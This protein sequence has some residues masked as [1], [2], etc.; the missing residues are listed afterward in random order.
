[1]SRSLTLRAGFATGKQ[2]IPANE[3]LL[4][5][6]FPAVVEDHLTLGATW[7]MGSMEFTAGY[8][9][10]FKKKVNG[11]GSVPPAFGAGE[12]NLRMHQDALG[13]AVGWKM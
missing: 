3:T 6:I 1:V 10:A 11:S 4:N 12:A 8:M 13:V 9:H 5:I 7:S 2:P